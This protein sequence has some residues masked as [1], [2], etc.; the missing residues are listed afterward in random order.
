MPAVSVIIRA[1]DEEA[2][3]GESLSRLQSQTIPREDVQLIVVDSGSSDRTAEIARSAGALVQP[4]PPSSYTFGRALNLGCALASAPIAVALSAHALPPDQGWLARMVGAMADEQVACSCSD[5]HGPDGGPLRG[6]IVQDEGLARQHPF[7][8]YSNAAGALRMDLWKR[9]AFRPDMPATE[10]K[11]WAWWWL[12]HGYRCVVDPVL[13]VADDQSKDPLR[14]IF[15]RSRREWVGFRMYLDPADYKAADLVRE[16]WRE[17]GIYSS[18]ARARLSHRRAARLLGK[19]VGSS[20]RSLLEQERRVSHLTVPVG[21]AVAIAAPDR[22]LRLAV[23]IDRFPKL[24][25]TFVTT[26]IAELRALGHQVGVEAVVPADDPNWP[27]AGDVPAAFV[28]DEH[29]AKKLAALSWLVARHPLGCARDLLS[30]HSW[31]QEEDVPGLRAL[32]GRA[33]RVDRRAVECMHVHFA[34]RSALDALRIG[35]ILG[36]PYSVTAHAYEIFSEPANLAEKLE[37]AALV[38]TG[39]DYNVAYLRSLLGAPVADRVH[40]MVMGVDGDVFSRR[41]PLTAGR[42]VVAVGRLVEKKGFHH[43][44]EA[45]ALL[46]RREPLEALVIAGEGAQRARLAGLAEEHGI[47]ALVSLPGALTPDAV[48]ALLERADVLAMPSIVAADGDRDSM[49]VVV[50]EA[51]AMELLVAASDEVGLP[52]AVMA[53]WGRLA[54]PGDVPALAGALEELLALPPEARAGAGR[55]GRDWVLE[56]ASSRREAQRLVTL[57]RGLP[58]A[59]S[60]QAARSTISPRRSPVRS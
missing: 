54:P 24:T 53:P 34:T 23:M 6:R 47:A 58:L 20:R 22:P 48:R 59:R 16:W 46:H 2:S 38:T 41:Q 51:M 44:I 7:W 29:P 33:R 18:L 21:A 35:R 30:R 45:C 11:E 1:R 14:E 40:E 50:K 8:G 31:K 60:R 5:D 19:Y 27:A 4:I 15:A 3:I 37:Y 26:E 9:R 56:H 17:P 32:A 28:T 36:I 43:L 12:R 39:C 10:D 52:E 13:R 42:T 55:A 25:E 57:L 49:P